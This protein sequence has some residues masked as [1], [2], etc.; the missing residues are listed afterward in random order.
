[1]SN[2]D[3]DTQKKH[4][5]LK[6]LL[7]SKQTGK[8]PDRSTERCIEKNWPGLN[9]DTFKVNNLIAKS[10][11]TD[12]SATPQINTETT[13]NV[14]SF[15]TYRQK[16]SYNIRKK[17]FDEYY[18]LFEE[19]VAAVLNKYNKIVENEMKYQFV[20]EKSLIDIFSKF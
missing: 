2:I 14:K 15:K 12:K 9:L 5:N 8:M 18:K 6:T 11:V 20:W 17:V 7:K 16:S 19:R 13:K 1:M 10:I 3:E 4:A